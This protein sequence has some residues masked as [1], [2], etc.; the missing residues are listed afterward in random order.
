M[1]R[2]VRS[3]QWEGRTRGFCSA[4]GSIPYAAPFSARPSGAQAPGGSGSARPCCIWNTARPGSGG[5]AEVAGRQ[6]VNGQPVLRGLRFNSYPMVLQAAEAGPAS[7]WD[8]AIS[9]IRW[10]PAGGWS[11]PSAGRWKPETVITSAHP[12]KLPV[13]PGSRNFFDGSPPRLRKHQTSHD[14]RECV[15]FGMIV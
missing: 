3:G 11:A 9:P 14:G 7:P 12:R 15:P 1:W 2:P 4:N 8:G 10:W 6:G 13:H 5:L